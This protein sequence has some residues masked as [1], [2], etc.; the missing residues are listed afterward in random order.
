MTYAISYRR[1]EEVGKRTIWSAPTTALVEA[2]NLQEAR[3]VFLRQNA[4]NSL[5]VEIL[6]VTRF[7][8]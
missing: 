6:K 4:G 7:R 5:N 1:K 8:L 3:S 2:S